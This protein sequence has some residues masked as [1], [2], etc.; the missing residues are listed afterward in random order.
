MNIV[1]YEDMFWETTLK[2]CRSALRF[3]S[4]IVVPWYDWAS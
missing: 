4:N 1:L 2:E 3:S